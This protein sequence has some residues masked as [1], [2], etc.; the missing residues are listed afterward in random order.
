LRDKK[1]RERNART[2]FLERNRNLY[3]ITWQ[4]PHKPMEADA[5]TLLPLVY[6]TPTTE[7]LLIGFDLDQE[8]LAGE[9]ILPEDVVPYGRDPN[10]GSQHAH[11]YQPGEYYGFSRGGRG[12]R[13]GEAEVATIVS[14]REKYHR[15]K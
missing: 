6:P 11:Q 13:Q 10:Q 3:F 12:P 9:N 15:L 8:L 7:E 2:F 4:S 1:L 14:M 5:R